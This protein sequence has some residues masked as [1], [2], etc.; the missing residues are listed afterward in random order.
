MQSLV[1]SKNTSNIW[2]TNCWYY[3]AI[4][5]SNVN[6]RANV[7]VTITEIKDPL[8]SGIVQIKS[9]DKIK[10]LNIGN[11]NATNNLMFRF[12]LDHKMP[13]ILNVSTATPNCLLNVTIG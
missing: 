7:N 10:D 1:V 2:C 5:N 13:F 6:V 12:T 8:L 9:G 11:N 4:Y 3:I